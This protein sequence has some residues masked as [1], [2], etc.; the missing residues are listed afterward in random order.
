MA[1]SIFLILVFGINTL[2]EVFVPPLSADI[3]ALSSRSS[4]LR[5]TAG[6]EVVVLDLQTLVTISSAGKLSFCIL[7]KNEKQALFGFV[8]RK[9]G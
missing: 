9:T 6:Q 4:G 3:F 5:L 2:D 7:E 1:F 8:R